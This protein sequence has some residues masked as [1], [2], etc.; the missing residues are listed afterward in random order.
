MFENMDHQDKFMVTILVIIFATFFAGLIA[1]EKT[2]AKNK[3]VVPKYTEVCIDGVIYLELSK[4]S[5]VAA[6]SPKYNTN[7]SIETCSNK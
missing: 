4:L 7:G 1:T 5:S 2:E 6:L 3:E